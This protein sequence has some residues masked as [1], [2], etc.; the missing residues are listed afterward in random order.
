LTAIVPLVLLAAWGFYST[1]V[2]GCGAAFVNR[3][4]ALLANAMILLD[5]P[6]MT[7]LTFQ[8]LGCLAKG[9]STVP[10]DLILGSEVAS[11]R[12]LVFANSAGSIV[13]P[14]A[15][16]PTGPGIQAVDN[17]GY[18]VKT[19]SKFAPSA[20]V[21]LDADFNVVATLTGLASWGATSNHLDGFYVLEGAVAGD[22][23]LSRINLAGE[24]VDEWTVAV[25]ANQVYALA[26][27][28]DNT[29]LYVAQTN[30]D[31]DTV[32]AYTL[33]GGS[34]VFAT[35][36]DGQVRISGGLLT[37][38]NGDVLICWAQPEGET[39]RYDAS[40]A[41]LRAYAEPAP[42]PGYDPGS[43]ICFCVGTADATFWRA[44]FFGLEEGSGGKNVFQEIDVATGAVLN[45]FEQAVPFPATLSVSLAVVR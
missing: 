35:E 2:R 32:T 29:T 11:P 3:N 23:T 24:I 45:S 22:A 44:Y 33:G 37:L 15:S 31:I 19:G 4:L 14:P 36:Q 42:D 40:G 16:N 39:K 12:Y 21:V 7:Y 30:V 13:L 34:A 9:L 6:A 41:F 26:V 38:R 1:I 18:L 27:S 43:Q 20:P 17:G 5:A 8:V 25:P 10:S 28:P